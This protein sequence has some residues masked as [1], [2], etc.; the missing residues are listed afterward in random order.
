MGGAETSSAG[1]HFA[2][3]ERLQQ[4]RQELTK[5]EK[6]LHKAEERVEQEQ[7]RAVD[8]AEELVDI[9]E[10]AKKY[11]HTHNNPIVCP[12]CNSSEFANDLPSKVDAE[13]ASFKSLAEA[14]RFRSSAQHALASVRRQG[15]Q[16]SVKYTDA[17]DRLSQL[18]TQ[19]K[20]PSDVL[21]LPTFT[22]AGAQ[23]R[24]VKAADMV[25]E[26]NAFL[27]AARDALKQRTEKKGFLQSL[28][29]AVETYD[30]NYSAQQERER[31]LPRLKQALEEIEQERH[32]FI[33]NILSQI[34]SRE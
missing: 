27:P 6:E 26:V 21:I 31:L 7:A 29:Q 2:E 25:G 16:Q 28:K 1:H 17:A 13:L 12:L 20:W 15:E 4:S 33:D 30:T 24:Q 14:L 5:S 19:K 34:T 32:Q 8:K 9:L 22:I 3:E 11:F 18:A 10:A 23:D